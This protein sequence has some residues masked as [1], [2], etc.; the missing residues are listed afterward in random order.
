MDSTGMDS[1]DPT[2]PEDDALPDGVASGHCEFKDLC[3]DVV[4][5]DVSVTF[6]SAALG[7]TV[8]PERNTMALVG[9]T[10]AER[11]WLNVVPEPK[12]VKNRVH[13]DLHAADLGDLTHLGA[14]PV[15]EVRSWTVM[16]DLEG[17][18]FC[19][20]LRP[21]DQLARYRLYELVVGSTDASRIA[22]WWAD[23]LQASVHRDAE[24]GFCWLESADTSAGATLIR[25]RDDEIA[26]DVL[27]D[28]D[29]NEFC[30][31]ART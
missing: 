12:T 28:P 19:V 20:F 25:A 15:A 21:P 1:T 29:G 16:Q 3:L 5:A 23:R 31:F 26:W 30:V 17:A 22:R 7:L 6:R 10:D 11:V 8:A 9:E 27:A 13:L 2:W 4:D 24:Q 18:E 14:R